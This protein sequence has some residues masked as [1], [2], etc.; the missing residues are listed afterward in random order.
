VLAPPEFLAEAEENG[1]IVEIGQRV[2]EEACAF[3]VGLR[4]LGFEIPVTVNV[5]YREFSQPVFLSALAETLT[6]HRLAPGS[7]L[8]DLRVDSLAR[9]ET[10]G[11]EVAEGLRGLGVGLAVDGFGA[12]VCDLGYLQEL[13]ACQIKLAQST[14][15]AIQEGG[16]AVAKTL[17]DIGHNLEMAVIGEAVET[18][19]QMEFLKSN[20]CD[21]IQGTWFSEP[22]QEDAACE[23]L[24]ARQFA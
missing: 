4:A 9:N 5:S 10:L 23:L 21:Q 12:G 6:R 22:L 19:A 1:V 14:V 13:C 15:H 18:R 20:G 17:I 8:L 2:L 3:A 11:R 24:R 7:L 16:N